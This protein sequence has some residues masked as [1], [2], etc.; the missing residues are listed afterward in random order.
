MTAPKTAREQLQ[1][2]LEVNGTTVS[3]EL[4]ASALAAARAEGFAE[5]RREAAAQR[6]QAVRLL[7]A[8]SQDHTTDC[9]SWRELSDNHSHSCD[10]G[11]ND[12]REFLEALATKQEGKP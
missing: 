2:W 4:F 9:D 11:A 8:Y 6:D 7:R 3:E 12:V 5:G 1:L 10:C